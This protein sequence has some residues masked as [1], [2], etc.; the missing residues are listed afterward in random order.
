MIPY[1]PNIEK[2]IFLFQIRVAVSFTKV[3]GHGVHFLAD[4][5]LTY[6]VITAKAFLNIVIVCIIQKVKCRG[7]FS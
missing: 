1:T 7:R 6:V 5:S 3:L 4:I 2:R